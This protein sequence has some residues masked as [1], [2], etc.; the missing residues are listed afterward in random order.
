MWGGAVEPCCTA[1]VEVR[2]WKHRFVRRPLGI[3]ATYVVMVSASVQKSVGSE[4]PEPSSGGC[5]CGAG[6]QC[7]ACGVDWT[8]GVRE[9][10]REVAWFGTHGPGR[11]CEHVTQSKEREVRRVV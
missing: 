9:G 7:Q 2:E 4:A 11:E 6:P 3:V 5:L 8:P 10:G 1:R